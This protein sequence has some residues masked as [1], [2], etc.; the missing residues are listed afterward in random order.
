[1][2]KLCS[3][4]IIVIAAAVP[5]VRCAAQSCKTK[6]PVICSQAA[7]MDTIKRDP[8]KQ[9]V[10][11]QKVILGLKLDLVYGT[12]RNFTGTVLYREPVAYMLS[13]PAYALKKVDSELRRRGLALKIYDAFRPFSV[14]CR[15]WQLVPDRRYAANP[16]KGS[17]HNRGLAADLTIVN[18]RTGT[19]L[20]MGTGFD[21]FSDTAHHAYLQ[22]PQ[23]VLDNRKLLKRLMWKYGF[24]PVPTEWWHYQWRTKEAYPVID[25]DFDVLKGLIGAY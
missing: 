23:Q 17:N 15:I 21:N 6:V 1:M 8:R 11:L 22:L 12:T 14:T 13:E 19:E 16:A 3:S 10:P 20:D 18:L 9:L 2:R 4:L 7:Y 5:Y 25:L 24:N